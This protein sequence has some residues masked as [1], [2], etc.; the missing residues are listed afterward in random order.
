MIYTGIGSRKTPGNILHSMV[1]VGEFMYNAGHTLRSGGAQGADRAF[2]IGADQAFG[3]AR[4]ARFGDVDA[5][6]IPELKEIYL[7]AYKW[8]GSDSPFYGVCEDAQRVAALFHPT[9]DR[10]SYFVKKLMGRNAYQILGHDLKTKTDFVVCWTPDGRITGGTGLALRMAV[11]H[12]IPVLNFGNLTLDE[13]N[14]RLE[15]LLEE[16]P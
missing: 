7:P 1:Q 11:Y 15:H 4:N 14:E 9:W 6:D 8:C 5:I 3:K 2:E 10:L 12:G 13:M 16:K